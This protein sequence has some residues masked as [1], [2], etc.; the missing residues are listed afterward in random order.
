M[1]I[2][3]ALT[4]SFNLN[5]KKLYLCSLDVCCVLFLAEADEQKLN[6]KKFNYLITASV[7]E[8]GVILDK[9][10]IFWLFLFVFT[11]H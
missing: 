5:S 3:E 11:F 10:F 2:E 1:T 8:N 7:G 6:H 4:L 9:N